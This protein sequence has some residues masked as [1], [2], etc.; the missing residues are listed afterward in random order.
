MF[1]L[2]SFDVTASNSQINAVKEIK[3][4]LSSTF[5]HQQNISVTNNF[6]NFDIV[7]T[8]CKSQCVL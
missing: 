7:K 2:T 6:I 4:S 5:L 8:K 1:Y 3:L